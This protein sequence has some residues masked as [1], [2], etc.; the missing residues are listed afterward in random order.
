MTE[1]EARKEALV[2]IVAVCRQVAYGVALACGRS[3]AEAASLAAKIM[4]EQF[5]V[6]INE[7]APTEGPGL[8]G[9]E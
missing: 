4:Q 8:G 2:A 7:E 6:E 3:E 5:G 1:D 9:E